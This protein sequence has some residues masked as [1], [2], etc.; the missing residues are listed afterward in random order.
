MRST[1]ESFQG[2]A[3]IGFEYETELRDINGKLLARNGGRNIFPTQGLN[4]MLNIAVGSVA[5][6]A[7]WYIGL[8]EGN[9][10]PVLGDTGAT[11]AANATESVAYDEA[12]R[13][14]LTVAAAAGGVITNFASPAVFTMN[15]SKTIYGA[16]VSSGSSKAGVTGTLLSAVRFDTAQVVNATNQL[17]VKSSATLVNN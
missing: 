5:K 9:Y 14:T 8:F 6:V 10:T 11:I 2:L 4:A 16:F 17:T 12:A 7:N 15:A 1:S 13:Q 3:A